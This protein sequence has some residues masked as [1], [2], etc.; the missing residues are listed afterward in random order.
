MTNFRSGLKKKKPRASH[1]VR[2]PGHDPEP[3]LF[4]S[5]KAD[6]AKGSESKEDSASLLA[7]AQGSTQEAEE[8]E[9]CNCPPSSD[10]SAAEVASETGPFSQEEWDRSMEH[11]NKN[12][13]ARRSGQGRFP[14]DVRPSSDRRQ[15]RE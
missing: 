2:F 12:Q 1:A 13:R 8:A 7:D 4:G 5:K 14:R 15:G 6:S 9:P 3:I 11:L 10:E